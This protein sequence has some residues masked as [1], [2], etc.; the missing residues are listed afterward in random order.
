MN[1]LI[2]ILD[3]MHQ[4]PVVIAVLIAVAVVIVIALMASASKAKKTDALSA[5]PLDLSDEQAQKVTMRRRRNPDSFIFRI[6]ASFA[7]DEIINA[8]ADEVAPRLGDGFQPTEVRV[9]PQKG[10][11]P[12]VYEVTFTKLE[13][14]R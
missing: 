3:W 11:K 9:I 14:L 6:P 7:T 1:T 4:H 5:K 2:T 8:W 10:W 13:S 12:S